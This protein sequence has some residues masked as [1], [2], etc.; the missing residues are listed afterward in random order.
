MKLM[1]V[2]PP[3][4]ERPTVIDEN[5]QI[6][7]LS[8]HVPDFTGQGV[9]LAALETIR[10]IDLTTLPVL[11]EGAR[12]GACLGAVP[13]FFC[14]G[15]NYAKH[16]AETG[17]KP[18]AEPILF[19]KAASALAGPNDAVTIPPGSEKSD[20]EVE[21]G[22]VI[23][24]P[25]WQVSEAEALDHVAGYCVVNDLSERAWQMEHGGQWIKGK[26]AP[27]YGPCGPWLVTADE[28]PDPQA[29]GLS[30]DLNGE[31]VQDSDTSDMIFGV[32]EIVSYMSR[33]MQ[34]V[35]GDLIAT[36]T[37]SGVGLGMKPPRF[38]RAGD[39]MELRVEK[40][41]EQRQE[42]VAAE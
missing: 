14:V 17:A 36:G 39:V 35:P 31:R 6:R 18:P 33:F 42:V 40:L 23:G 16:A 34:L 22:V 21:L 13:N 30:L 5:G 3:G 15:L 25:C 2:G 9:S 20:W 24:K 11:P 27:G 37:P 29:L 8:G 26:S 32:A 28:V 10:G 38:L 4:E 19:S 41:G 7:D 12:I 1:R